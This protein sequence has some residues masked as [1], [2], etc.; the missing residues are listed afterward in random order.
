[1]TAPLRKTIVGDVSGLPDGAMGPANLVWWGNLGFMLIEGTA[2]A[3]AIGAYFYL[4]SQSPGWPPKGD[5]PPDLLWGS[6]FTAAMLASEIPNRLVCARA[7][8][9]DPHGVRWGTLGMALIG[10]VLLGIRA[11]ELGHLNI[12]WDHDAYGS[13]VWMLM[14]LHTS[15]LVTELGETSVQSVWLF[16]HRIETDQ[17]S[18]VQD[19]SEYWSF[20]VLAWLPLYLVLYWVPRWL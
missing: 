20:V 16:T 14:V 8:A 19:N 5:A 12:R 15:H 6:I 18:D 9:K 10:I 1:M 17:F 13:V 4:Q 2:F 11:F 7:R 3:L